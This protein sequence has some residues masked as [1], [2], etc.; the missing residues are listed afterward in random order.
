M[1][2]VLYRYRKLFVVW[3]FE[4]AVVVIAMHMWVDLYTKCCHF[5]ANILKPIY[6]TR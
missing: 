1:I 6:H 2:E 4:A 5:P 3:T